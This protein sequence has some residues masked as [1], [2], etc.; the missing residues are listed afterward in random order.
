MVLIARGIEAA[1]IRPRPY[2]PSSR[3]VRGRMPPLPTSSTP[4]LGRIAS[5]PSRRRKLRTARSL[6][7][8]IPVPHRTA[9]LEAAPGADGSGR[10]EQRAA[11]APADALVPV[12]EHHGVDR[13]HPAQQHP[14]HARPVGQGAPRGDRGHHHRGVDQVV[15]VAVDQADAVAARHDHGGLGQGQAVEP[16][17]VAAH[18]HHRRHPLE[19]VE[20]RQHA[21]VAGVE[22]QVAALERLQHAPRAGRR[23]TRR[24]ACR[25]PPRCGSAAVPPRL[26]RP[27]DAEVD[28]PAD[29]LRVADPAR[30]PSA[31]A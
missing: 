5:G 11:L 4:T 22:D 21:E 8:V 14:G 29:Q 28:Q 30:P 20:H 13:T 17:V 23:G 7:P 24:R 12:A 27:G 18:R 16:V 15:A 26:R 31:R 6:T 19:V 10:E 25:R 9:P 3:M 2:R 1:G